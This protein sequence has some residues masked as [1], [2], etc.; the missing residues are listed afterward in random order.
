MTNWEHNGQK[1]LHLRVSPLA[2]ILGQSLNYSASCDW[3]TVLLAI[4]RGTLGFPSNKQSLQV[5]DRPNKLNHLGLCQRYSGSMRLIWP[6]V[7]KGSN[8]A[9]T[10]R[11]AKIHV[12]TFDWRPRQDRSSS[13]RCS[14]NASPGLTSSPQSGPS[15]F[16]KCFDA[17]CKHETARRGHP[18]SSRELST[19]EDASFSRWT[20]SPPHQHQHRHTHMHTHT[21]S[22]HAGSPA[23]RRRIQ[24]NVSQFFLNSAEKGKRQM[25][26]EACNRSIG[27][28]GTRAAT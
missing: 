12:P 16:T 11:R 2:L 19:W 25:S 10:I 20:V 13:S 24:S 6:Q 28:H 23:V 7:Q 27:R 15:C 5:Q 17:V 3:L 1:L 22:N 14:R 8:Q 21:P 9:E 26:K 4:V 18:D